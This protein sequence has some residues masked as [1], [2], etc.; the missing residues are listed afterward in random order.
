M[1]PHAL[2]DT[3]T[4]LEIMQEHLKQFERREFFFNWI[5]AM[6]KTWK[7]NF[8]PELKSKSNV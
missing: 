6:N 7:W 2:T 5:T 3:Q 4:R 1:V 8:E